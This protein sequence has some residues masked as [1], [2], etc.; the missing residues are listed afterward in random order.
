LFIRVMRASLGGG[1]LSALVS[2]FTS[3]HVIITEPRKRSGRR[4]FKV[5][6]SVLFETWLL[7]GQV[8]FALAPQVFR[9]CDYVT[10]RSLLQDFLA[11]SALEKAVVISSSAFTFRPAISPPAQLLQLI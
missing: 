4:P 3:G 1:A 2:T 10:A 5:I 7:S 9:S 8:R 6:G 11:V